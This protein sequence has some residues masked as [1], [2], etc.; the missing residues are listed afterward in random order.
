MFAS[1]ILESPCFL[2]LLLLSSPLF[3]A[4]LFFFVLLVLDLPSCPIY[5]Q[6]FA[7]FSPLFDIRFVC[8]LLSFF[9]HVRKTALWSV[10]M[11]FVFFDSAAFGFGCF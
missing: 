1:N 6:V 8:L 11:N 3:L 7:L 9:A 10:L 5:L 2:L 4:V